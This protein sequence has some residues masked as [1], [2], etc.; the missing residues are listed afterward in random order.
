MKLPATEHGILFSESMVLANLARRK[1]QTRRTRGLDEINELPD[2]WK[3]RGILKLG[4]DSRYKPGY[5]AHFTRGTD[6]VYSQYIRLPYGG[7][8]HKLWGRETLRR[9]KE[10]I[11]TY[12]ADGKPLELPEGDPR[13]SQ[14]LAWAHHKD[15]DVC[16]SIH[17][18][19]WA[20]RLVLPID[21]VRV[22][23]LQDITEEDSIAEGIER[24]C[25][26]SIC[27]GRGYIPQQNTVVEPDTCRCS[28]YTSL[29]LY[30]Q[31]W[32][33]INGPGSWDA[34]PWVWAYT[35]NHSELAK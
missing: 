10:G 30:G 9:T 33:S 17:M 21:E 19:R 2:A 8:G 29:E 4:G 25:P 28:D 27:D 35:Y 5:H 24:W 6:L 1:R 16:V 34:N 23:R 31:L 18:P 7:P 12:A 13:I 11:W 20:S 32:E 22:E 26:Y 15:G 14:M 3:F